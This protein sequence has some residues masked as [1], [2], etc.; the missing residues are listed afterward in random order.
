MSIDAPLSSP[1]A[2]TKMSTSPINSPAMR[3]P[4]FD[5]LSICSDLS[6]L[7][8]NFD[9]DSVSVRNEQL[10]DKHSNI[11]SNTTTFQLKPFD[12]FNDDRVLKYFHKEVERYE[13]IMESLNVKMLNGNTQLSAKWKELHDL[14]FKDASKRTTTIARLFPEKNRV[15]DCIPYDHARVK[16]EKDTDD[17]INAAYVKVWCCK[18]KRQLILLLLIFKLNFTITA[19]SRHRLSKP[20]YSTNSTTKYD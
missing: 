16:L 2:N 9:W 12:P 1:Q 14:L 8:T 4:S 13:K 5:N 20:Y 6:S 3:K 11:S 17:Y 10:S 19:E 18:N 7:D 15:L